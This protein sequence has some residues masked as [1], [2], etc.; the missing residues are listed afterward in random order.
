MI[1]IRYHIVSITAVFLA[2]GIGV[3]LGSTFLDRATVDVLDRNIRNAEQ[4]IRDTEAENQR[5]S[6]QVEDAG[7][8]DAALLLA[9]GPELLGDQL[10][11]VPVVVVRAPGVDDQAVEA[12]RTALR[13]ADADLRGTLE[14]QDSLALDGNPDKELATALDLTDPSGSTLRRATY[15]SLGEALA[16]GAQTEAAVPSGPGG[17]NGT[18]TT[19]SVPEGEA[20]PTTEPTTT[21]GSTTT[22]TEP[23]RAS[24]PEPGAVLITLLDRSYLRYVPEAG[25]EDDPVLASIGYRYVFV[26]QAGTDPT[27]VG[28][29]VDLLNATLDA[30]P[31][32]AVVV[33]P[34]TAAVP[35]GQDPPTPSAV[36]AVR[37]S[38]DLAA[39][40]STDDESDTFA[41]LFATVLVVRDLPTASVGHYGQEEGASAVLPPIP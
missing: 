23:A 37:N 12:V 27:Q 3:A 17:T 38:K 26:S 14:M 41:G 40:Y 1:N 4:R 33:S 28:V 13:D 36:A 20:P 9:G 19:T 7:N 15:R 32:P 30:T 24:T 16:L 25:H 29:M 34:R 39:R 35:E 5:L 31:L 21:T 11:D 8:R 18:T 10:V 22:T 6:K 2:L